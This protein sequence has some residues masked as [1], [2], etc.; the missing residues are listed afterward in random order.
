MTVIIILDS[1]LY[2]SP[3]VDSFLSFVFAW[4][5]ILSVSLQFLFNRGLFL[6]IAGFKSSESPNKMAISSAQNSR[7]K[8]FFLRKLTG[9]V[10]QF[11]IFDYTLSCFVFSFL[12]LRLSCTVAQF[13]ISTWFHFSLPRILS[14]TLF[15]RSVQDTTPEGVLSLNAGA[16]SLWHSPPQ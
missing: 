13:Q 5:W 10:P 16:L 14:F 11:L 3:V 15:T 7:D 6:L 12:H 1:L 9:F 4:S 8:S 2:H